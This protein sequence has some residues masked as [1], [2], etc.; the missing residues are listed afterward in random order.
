MAIRFTGVGL[1][2]HGRVTEGVS[3]ISLRRDDVVVGM[4]VVRTD[5][6]LLVVTEGG[7]GK[8]SEVDEYRLQKRGGKGVINM[9]FPGR[10]DRGWSRSGPSLRATS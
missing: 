8:R 1:P 3:G 2:P 6:T 10:P 7:M 9:K 5:S 4:V